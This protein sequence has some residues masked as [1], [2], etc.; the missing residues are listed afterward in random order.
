[1]RG[2]EHLARGRVQPGA[3]HLRAG[4]E[5]TPA[6]PTRPARLLT[7]V[8]ALLVAGDIATAVEYAEQVAALPRDAWSDYVNGYL[9]LVSGDQAGARERLCRAYPMVDSDRG[10]G[11]DAPPGLRS[12]IAS[13]LAILG[14]VSVN[15]ADMVTYGAAAVADP[16]LPPWAAAFAWFTRAL[17]LS[18]AG[19]SDAALAELTGAHLPGS[20]AG[21]D[22][23]VARGMIRLWSD[24]L[25]GAHA[26][27]GAALRR[28]VRGEPLR[29][30]Q[31]LGFLGE[32]EYRRGEL[33]AAATHTELAVGDAEENNRVWDYAMLHGLAC[34]PLAAQAEW[35]AAGA[36]AEQA[37]AWARM[38]GT[39]AAVHDEAAARAALGQAR[40]VP[41]EL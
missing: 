19:H 2:A 10:A 11:G 24:D 3:A 36:H 20:P 1:R 5:L 32:A 17:G 26:D 27:L 14:V 33:V 30:G 16:D 13:Q 28:A 12:R 25:D 8:E 7:A 18:V 34:Y 21:L 40:G 6:G 15:Y 37:T 23:L 4:L 41:A 35:D 9:L 31:L 29:I 38:T 22:G 39:P